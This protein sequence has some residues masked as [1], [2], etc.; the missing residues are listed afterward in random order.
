MKMLRLLKNLNILTLTLFSGSFSGVGP[1][2]KSS[3]LMASLKVVVGA[4]ANWVL[5]LKC[6]TFRVWNSRVP[7]FTVLMSSS[8]M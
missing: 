3:H 4:I 1:C 8:Q 2:T 5:P 7:F 6:L